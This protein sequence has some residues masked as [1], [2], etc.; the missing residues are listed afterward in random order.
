[1]TDTQQML[2]TTHSCILQHPHWSVLDQKM[3]PM[4]MHLAIA[5]ISNCSKKFLNIII[6]ILISL[7]TVA[8]PDPQTTL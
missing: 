5:A 4:N 3:S 8:S 2:H 7:R 1:M 6:S